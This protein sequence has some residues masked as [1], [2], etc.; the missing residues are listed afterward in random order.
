[1]L[2]PFLC[3]S[4]V[5]VISSCSVVVVV[6]VVVV[7]VGFFFF[8]LSF[9]AVT[10][11]DGVIDSMASCRR[12]EYN[13]VFRDERCDCRCIAGAEERCG[14]PADD[15]DKDGETANAVVDKGA[16]AAVHGQ[17]HHDAAATMATTTAARVFVWSLFMVLM[18]RSTPVIFKLVAKSCCGVEDMSR[19]LQREYNRR[20]SSLPFGDA[21]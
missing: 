11:N 5:T 4:L 12:N 1:M 19:V 10:V 17:H 15:A 16:E 6:V 20:V 2:A 18:V 14:S 9:S 8:F 7:F 13:L 21:T 3:F